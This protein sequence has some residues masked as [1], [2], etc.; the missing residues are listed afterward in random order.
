MRDPTWDRPAVVY[1][2]KVYAIRHELENGT[3]SFQIQI[4]SQVLH[5]QAHSCNQARLYVRRRD[6]ICS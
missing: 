2:T 3:P 6:G 4:Q 1:D 5:L